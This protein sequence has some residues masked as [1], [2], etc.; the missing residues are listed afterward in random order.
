MTK[1]VHGMQG[2][3]YDNRLKVLNLQ[4]L[5][6]RRTRS[7]LIETFKIINNNYNIN[8]AVFFDFDD[9]GRRG[10]SKKLF[11]KRFR[12]DVKKYVFSNR[13]IDAWNC[14]SQDCVN[15]STVNTFKASLASA[16]KPEDTL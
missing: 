4:R 10:H 6:T 1:L 12:L 3:C 13:V 11:K 14:L 8:S 15:S 5:E 7:D 16:L 9:S 2:L